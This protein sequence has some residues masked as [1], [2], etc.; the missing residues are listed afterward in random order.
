MTLNSGHFAAL[1]WLTSWANSGSDEHQSRGLLNSVRCD[2]EASPILIFMPR[3]F[4]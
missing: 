4:V 2:R 3:R 1:R